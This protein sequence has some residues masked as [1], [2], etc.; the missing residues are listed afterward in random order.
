[1]NP[2]VRH[3]LTGVAALLVGL[4]L[5]LTLLPWRTT[6]QVGLVVGGFLWHM[7][8]VGAVMIPLL[9]I[10][11]ALAAFDR[12]GSVSTVRAAALGAGLIVIAP[13]SVAIVTGVHLIPADYALW[14][15]G[16]QLVGL[17]PA[18]QAAHIAPARALRGE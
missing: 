1:V 15:R 2:K 9:G 5:G 11:W 13:Y 18:W 12:L 8:G 17:I 3:E 14:T 16:E 10:G 6:G 7:F 4:F